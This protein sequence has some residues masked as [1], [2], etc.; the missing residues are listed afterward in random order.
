MSVAQALRDAAARLETIS[1]T[2]RLDAELLLAHALGVSRNDLLMRQ[3]DL[4]V[5]PGFNL[6]LDRRLA[7]EPIAY[8][9]GTRDF[10]TISLHV[11]PDVLIPRPDTETLI[12]A[13]VDHFS[14]RAPAHVLD[15]G[16]GSGALL[17]AALS[18]WPL[19]SGVGVDVSSAA[20]AV[21]RGNAQRLGL[22]DRADFHLGD[23]AEGMEGPFDLILINPPYIARNVLLSGDVLHEPD[24][25]LFAGAEGL[26]DYRRIAPMLP[27]LLAP[28]GMA[29]IEIGYDQRVS[30]SAL[31]AEQGLGISA[32]RDLA[33]HDRCLVATPAGLA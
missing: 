22:A 1:G 17:L 14:K 4:R 11:T 3:R 9:T 7:G 20:L 29:A 10:W 33:G 31:L 26:D 24:G 12:E 18:Q 13:A 28:G 23:W 2:P 5:P 16:T 21:A 6:F 32:R 30:V 25:A 15:L 27:R 8:I 19:A